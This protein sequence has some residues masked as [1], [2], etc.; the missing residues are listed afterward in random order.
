M[1]AMQVREVMKGKK[2]KYQEVKEIRSPN[3]EVLGLETRA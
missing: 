3:Q 1:K 2:V